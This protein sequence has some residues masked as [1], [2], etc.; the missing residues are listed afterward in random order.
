ME[1]RRR[2]VP[3]YEHR[4]ARFSFYKVCV[5]GNDGGDLA[6]D[7]FLAAISIH[8]GPGTFAG[9]SVGIEIPQTD[10]TLAGLISNFPHANIRVGHRH[11][12]YGREVEVEELAGNP[13][14]AL[15]QLVEL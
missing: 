13:E 7:S 8:P 10:V 2:I 9:A 11:V 15:A 6:L 3:R 1:H 12:C 4:L 5:V 14:D